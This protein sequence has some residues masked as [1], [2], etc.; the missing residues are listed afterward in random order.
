VWG[1]DMPNAPKNVVFTRWSI[2]NRIDVMAT[3]RGRFDFGGRISGAYRG[4]FPQIHIIFQ[5]ATAPTALVHVEGNPKDYP[6]LDYFLQGAPYAIRKSPSSVLILGFGGG[7]DGLIAEHAGAERI[8]GVDINPITAGLV[9]Q[10]YR[11]FDPAL[12]N[13]QNVNLIVS[14][15]RNYLT[16][17]SNKFDVIQLSGVDTFAALSAGA[18]AL[19]ENYLYT[20]EAVDD[21]LNHLSDNGVLSYSRWLF[22]P[23]RETL[24][25]VVTIREALRRAG[26]QDARSHIVIVAGGPVT[27]PWA[28]TMVK[29]TPF[30]EEEIEALRTWARDRQFGLIYSPYHP[31]DNYYNQYLN[32][33][34]QEQKAFVANYLY[35]VSPSTD[36]KPFFFQFYRWKD[37]WHP[38]SVQGFGGY[39]FGSTPKGLL[40]LFVALV[41]MT[42]LSLVFV[43]LPLGKKRVFDVPARSCLSWMIV[44]GGLGFGFIAI[45]MVL[46]QKLSV[47]L[48]GPAYSMTITLAALLV[49]SGLGSGLSQKSAASG[50]GSIIAILI[51]LLAIQGLELLFLDFGVRA[52]LGLAPAF[53]YAAA[54]V[55]IAPLGLLMGMPFPGLLGKAG[56]SSEALIPWAWG[57]N[58]CATVVGSVLSTIASMTLGLNVSWALAVGAYAAVLLVVLLDL[59]TAARTRHEAPE[60]P[61]RVDVKSEPESTLVGVS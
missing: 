56:A 14:E 15:G 7:I 25:L 50:W 8:T 57:V 5:D 40:S 28:D 41:E 9:S 61:S 48:G 3:E 36:N 1:K 23:P 20:S 18:F 38:A 30:T 10:R 26:I 21:L 27:A 16:R 35:D 54:V 53:R 51:A 58:A 6:L 55:A 32:G 60:V 13:G 43:L 39:S 19:S 11:D 33:S 22:A 31:M 59:Q 17:T 2:L 12:W 34:D 24:R 52:M 45:E 46:M 37:I 42:I 29:K 44:F 49:F 47:F 4:E